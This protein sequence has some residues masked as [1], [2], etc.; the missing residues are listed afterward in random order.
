MAVKRRIQIQYTSGARS[1]QVEVYPL[2]SHQRLALGRDPSCEVRFHPVDD[3]VVS[4]NHALIEW[5]SEDP[6]VFRL[7]DL[8]SSNGTFV[9]GRR[10]GRSA[11]LRVGDVVRLGHGGP[12]FVFDLADAD[13]SAEQSRER[14]PRTMEIPLV[15]VR[16]ALPKIKP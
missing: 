3:A 12:E 10:I 7:V 15:T 11:M 4:R 1:G 8:L 6:P 16:Q 5:E 14:A 2:A 13:V 9:N